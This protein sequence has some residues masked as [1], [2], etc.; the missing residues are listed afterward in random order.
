MEKIKKYKWF[1]LVLTILIFIMIVNIKIYNIIGKNIVAYLK[2]YYFEKIVNLDEVY[3]IETYNITNQVLKV[4]DYTFT[5][6]QYFL[7][8][9]NNEGCCR[10]KISKENTDMRDIHIKEDSFFVNF[11]EGYRFTF[12]VWASDVDFGNVGTTTERVRT[13]KKKDTMYLYYNFYSDD[14][15]IYDGKVYLKDSNVEY[16]KEGNYPKNQVGYFDLKE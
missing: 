8:P 4:E 3:N 2:E 6:D 9:K 14:G 7:N 16:P 1:V 15:L 13:I 12:A 5:M 11:G 10:I